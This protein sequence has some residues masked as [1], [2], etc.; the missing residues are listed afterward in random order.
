MDL[1]VLAH[2][3]SEE[4]EVLQ[5]AEE[6]EDLCSQGSQDQVSPQHLPEPQFKKMQKQNNRNK[7]L[8]PN[9]RSLLNPKLQ[10]Q[11]WNN[12]RRSLLK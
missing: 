5:W 11:K 6:G 7:N 2:Q 4:V 10:S 8:K 9:Q 1:Q 12:P 3:V